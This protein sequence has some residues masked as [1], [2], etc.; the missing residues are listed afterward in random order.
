MEAVRGA[1]NTNDKEV[2]E[3]LAQVCEV[4]ARG[5]VMAY[6]RLKITETWFKTKP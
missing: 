1:M 5:D 3:K 6:P 2:T 4:M